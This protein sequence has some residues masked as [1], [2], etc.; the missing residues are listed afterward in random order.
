MGKLDWEDEINSCIPASMECNVSHCATRL[1]ET[2][3]IVDGEPCSHA[4]AWR[5][6]VQVD[7]FRRVFSLQKE[8]LSD[9]KRRVGIA[10]LFVRTVQ[11]CHQDIQ[12]RR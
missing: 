4:S 1:V 9:Y 11:Q 2:Y 5:V 6:D 12:N 10:Y 7:R 8:H 3:S